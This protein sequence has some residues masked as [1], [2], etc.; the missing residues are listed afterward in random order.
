MKSVGI[1]DKINNAANKATKMAETYTQKMQKSINDSRVNKVETSSSSSQS[2][3][4]IPH[5]LDMANSIPTGIDDNGPW[6][7]VIGHAKIFPLLGKALEIPKNLDIYN[8]YRAMFFDLARKYTDIAEKEYNEKIHDYITFMEL[9]PLIYDSNLYPILK[10]ALDILIS[11]NVWS[12]T[13]EEFAAKHKENFH[14]AIDDYATMSESTA[15]TLQANQQVGSGMMSFAT[16]LMSK[17]FANNPFRESLDKIES[18]AISQTVANIGISAPQQAELYQRINSNKLFLR[19]FMDY[20]NVL[21]SL[22]TILNENGADIWMLSSESSES[23]KSIFK[24]LSNPH[25]PQDKVV[26]AFLEILKTNPYNPDYHEFMMSKFGDTKETIA[27]KNY[28]G[29]TNSDNPRIA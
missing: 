19:V 4:Y 13:F 17:K 10:R 9:F 25:F 29:Y 26:D 27:I 28:F 23:A 6:E 11:E 7:K 8:S 24:N 5:P 14:L 3:S 20:S 2:N 12:I 22:I 1:F 18:K 21:H 16:G 15:L